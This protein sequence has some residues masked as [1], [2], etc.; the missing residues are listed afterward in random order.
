MKEASLKQALVKLLD[1]LEHA[2]KR[3][4]MYF[5]TLNPNP[6]RMGDWLYGIGIGMSVFEP[7]LMRIQFDDAA[8]ERRGIEPSARN[9]A[10]VLAEMGRPPDG[11]AMM[12]LE[13]VE[14][15][16]RE[17]LTKLERGA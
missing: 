5:G 6:E 4:E 12:L 17:R 8:W 3:P 13:V 1:T 11:I 10:D 7:S 9:P 14:E 15:V 16:C 2:R